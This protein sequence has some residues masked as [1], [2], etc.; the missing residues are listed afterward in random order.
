MRCKARCRPHRR[1]RSPPRRAAQHHLDGRR[2]SPIGLSV[3]NK[4]VASVPR[5]RSAANGADER[6]VAGNQGGRAH[7]LV[8]A[9][10]RRLSTELWTEYRAR[11]ERAAPGQAGGDKVRGE[12]GRSRGKAMPGSCRG[13]RS[14]SPP[15]VDDLSDR[16]S[17]HPI[18]RCWNN[19]ASAIAAQTSTKTTSA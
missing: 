17:Q 13:P 10:R 4:Q 8:S 16:R 3:I 7:C 19:A 11:R 1:R 18:H 9:N 12:R 2:T 6:R 15:V 5:R 14:V